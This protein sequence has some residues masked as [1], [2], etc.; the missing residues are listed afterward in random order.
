MGRGARM[1]DMGTN[2]TSVR[3]KASSQSLIRGGEVRF[4]GRR[5]VFITVF[6]CV[7]KAYLV[8]RRVVYKKQTGHM[9]SGSAEVGPTSC[10][11]AVASALHT[12]AP[13]YQRS[14]ARSGRTACACWATPRF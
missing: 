1:I 11:S 7:A 2:S 3:H 12:K 8:C 5:G 4:E 6:L 9:C 13:K 14:R 10:A